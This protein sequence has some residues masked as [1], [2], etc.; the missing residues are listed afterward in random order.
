M[1]IV[2][3]SDQLQAR[4]LQSLIEDFVTRDGSVQGHHERPL[5]EKIQAVEKALRTGHAV[6]VFN[7]LEETFTIMPHAEWARAEKTASEVGEKLIDDAET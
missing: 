5:Q 4:T 1:N 7:D 6:I 2:V 3:P